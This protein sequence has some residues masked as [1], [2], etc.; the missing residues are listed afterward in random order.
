MVTSTFAEKAFA[1]IHH[2]FLVETLKKIEI[3]GASSIIIKAIFNKLNGGN[4]KLFL[5]K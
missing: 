1:N 4:L 5:L 2:H 3:K